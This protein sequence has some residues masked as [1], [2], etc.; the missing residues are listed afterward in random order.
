MT[1]AYIAFT[2]L[3]PEVRDRAN[4]LLKLNPYYSIWFKAIPAGSSEADKQEMI[5][6]LS[7][8]WP[9]EIKRDH[10]YT[11]DGTDNGNRPDG[12]TS[13]QNVGYS[14]PLL[15]KYWHF[16]DIPFT[17]DGTPL[18]GPP[19][20]NARTQIV[21]FRK[22]LSSSEPDALKSYDLVWLLHLV[23]DVH[24]PLHC[25][26]RFSKDLPDGDA[27]A[28]LVKLNP[29]PSN[30]ELHA[31]WDDILGTSDNPVSAI[32]LGNRIAPADATLASDVN[33]D[34][35][36]NESFE[37]AEA[38][39]YVG[40][41]GAGAGPFTITAAYQNSARALAEKRVALAGG[42][43]ANVLNTELK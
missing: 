16:V 14:D 13:S 1:V 29:Q 7:A 21:V 32:N 2:K 10:K 34:D 43:L 8:T 11:A 25:A 3:K 30:N 38:D 18:S 23:G 17:Q 6:M 36:V 4:A 12:A 41:I 5:F 28:N 15:H 40:P 33:V 39:V 22:V 27:G 37:D 31:F 42:R 24:Q 19:I 20:P 9:D 26:S 35:W